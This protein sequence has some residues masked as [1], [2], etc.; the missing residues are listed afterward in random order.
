M[1]GLLQQLYDYRSN[2]CNNCMTIEIMS[3]LPNTF[4]VIS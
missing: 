3:K 1:S 2:A 4:I